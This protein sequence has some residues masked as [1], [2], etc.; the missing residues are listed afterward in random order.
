MRKIE[1]SQA[2]PRAALLVGLLVVLV[3]AVVAPSARA[4]VNGELA[5][6]RYPAVGTVV[7]QPGDGSPMFNLCTGFLT[8]NRALVTAGHCAV[9]ALNVQQQFGGSIGVS[10]D[11]SFDPTS[12][13]IAATDVT[14]HPEFLDKQLSYKSPDMAVLTLS[15]DV[16]GVDPIDLPDEGQADELRNGDLLTTVGY[17]LI[18]QC[19]TALGHCQVAYDP[20]RRFAT[21]TV[22]SVSQWFLTVG[23]NPNSGGTGGVCYGDSGGPHLLAGTN[24]AVALTTAIFSKLCYATSRDIRLDTATALDFLAPYLDS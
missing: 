1:M 19:D 20:A 23:Q 2:V 7:I 13:F 11:P 4:I 17:G 10:F 22:K 9:D 6:D 5:G 3:A 18:Q 21:E 14:V 16:D 12:Q 15:E 8:S 24:T